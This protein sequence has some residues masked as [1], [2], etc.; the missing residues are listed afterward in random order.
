MQSMVA[1]FSLWRYLPASSSAALCNTVA[2]D[3]HSISLQATFAS[4]AA[5]IARSASLGLARW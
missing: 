5:S 2:R 4:F 1:A 3:D